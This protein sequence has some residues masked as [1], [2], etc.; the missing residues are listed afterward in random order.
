MKKVALYCRVSSDDQRERDTIENQI[1]ILRTYIEM[2]E[3]LDIYNEYLDNGISGTIP[4]NER[5]GGSILLADAQ[6]G[7]FDTILV[8][9]IDRF[10]RDT[11]SGL[12]AVEM[13]RKY[14]IEIISV[15]EP[16]DLN[17]PTG[18]FQ[19]I[20]YLNMAELERNNILDRMYLGATRAAKKG[21]WLGGIVPY[22]YVVNKDG[23]LE[24]N[25]VEADIIR[26]IFNLYLNENM[27]SLDIAVYLNNLDIPSSCGEGKG[28]RTKGITGKWR[29]SSIQRILSNTTYYGV[30]SYGKRGSR[31]KELIYREV[32]GIVSKEDWDNAQKIKKE[33]LLFSSRNNKK[34]EYLLRGLINCSHCGKKFYGVS[35]TNKS[36]SYV[37][38]GKRGDNKKVL[39]LKCDNLNIKADLIEEHV[40]NDCI[41]ILTNYEHYVNDMKNNENFNNGSDEVSADIDKLRKSLT[42]KN[43]EKNN[44]LTL[45]RKGLIDEDEVEFQLKDIKK[46]ESKI[47]NLISALT[48]KLD[49]FNHDDEL[50]NN[51]A[52]KLKLY[53][54]RLTKLSFEEKY[55]VVK[56][57]VKG[58]KAETIIEDGGKKSNI[59]IVYNLVKL[60]NCTDK[61]SKL[62]LA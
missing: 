17:T 45:F 53:H 11:L 9:K 46:E 12:N 58:I 35:Y 56:L 4:F 59:T 29:S 23:F 1:E 6:K 36:A 31:R 22:G 26:S 15:T 2:K 40:W 32:P 3:S 20:T 50:I 62:L 19:F 16:F 39:N 38:S 54:E 57:L 25:E 28:K 5:P 60:E 18:R 30:H 51:M 43:Q 47:N 7:L 42:D 48:A 10:G 44:I 14:D 13:L 24:I 61:D 41:E 55:E 33:N 49:S 37:C 21:K 8:W 52:D 34:R 27:S